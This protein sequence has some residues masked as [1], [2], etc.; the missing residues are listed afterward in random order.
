MPDRL[1]VHMRRWHDSQLRRVSWGCG[2]VGKECFARAVEVAKLDLSDSNVTPFTL[3]NTAA[4][5][6]DVG[7]TLESRHHRSSSS[8]S[9]TYPLAL[10]Y[11]PSCVIGT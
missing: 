1:L 9:S 8:A 3:R 6:S 5:E 7:I 11:L 2:Q 4:M 10:N